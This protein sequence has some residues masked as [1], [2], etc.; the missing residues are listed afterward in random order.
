MDD[1]QI[2]NYTW[3]YHAKGYL[4]APKL[5]C[6][7]LLDSKNFRTDDDPEAEGLN[8]PY[9]LELLFPTILF[10]TKH[11]I[12]V[13][14][15]TILL[16]MDIEKLDCHDLIYLFS[17]IKN[18]IDSIN[19]KTQEKVGITDDYIKKV[20]KSVKGELNKLILYFA[21]NLIVNEKL[22]TGSIPDPN[23]ELFRYPEMKKVGKKFSFDELISKITDSDIKKLKM[24]IAL[25]QR[26][27]LNV[28]YL[29]SVNKRYY[30]E[31]FTNPSAAAED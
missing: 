18:K 30:P 12:E 6:T 26:L 20:K 9:M 2:R 11:G 21:N 5:C 7:E 8:M 19:W 23:N 22:K 14:L 10:N 25:I 28:G 29:I 1:K 15:K 17:L 24:K 4:D 16:R 3:L 13:M 31:I 27:L